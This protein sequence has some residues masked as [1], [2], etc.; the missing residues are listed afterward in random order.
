MSDYGAALVIEKRDKKTIAPEEKTRILA[1]LENVRQMGD[2][3]DVLG[4]S[5]LF[6]VTNTDKDIYV[7]ILLSRYWYGEGD[8]RENFEMG[9]ENDLG[10]AEEVASLL[11]PRLGDVFVIEP[12]F[13]NW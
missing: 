9:Q 5:F 11:E 8:D 12:I 10:Q 3:T 7:F 1:E 4:E 13:E 6:E 2:F